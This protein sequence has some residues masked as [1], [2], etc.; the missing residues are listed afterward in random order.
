MV[1]CDG[2]MSWV[3]LVERMRRGVKVCECTWRPRDC[4]C[5]SCADECRV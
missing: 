3:P 5:G 1:A 4:E 2:E